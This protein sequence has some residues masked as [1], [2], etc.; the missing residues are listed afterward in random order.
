MSAFIGSSCVYIGKQKRVGLLVRPQV[1]V[2]GT[3][4]AHEQKPAKWSK[5]EG[6]SGCGAY[7]WQ[8]SGWQAS[9]GS[10]FPKE[11]SS[12]RVEVDLKAGS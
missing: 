9:D 1:W 8:L 3:G 11:T 10:F 7:L 5:H 6:R 4:C 2:A 12:N